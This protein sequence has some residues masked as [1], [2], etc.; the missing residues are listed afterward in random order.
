[1]KLAAGILF[2]TNAAA[3]VKPLFSQ[4]GVKWVVVPKTFRRLLAE[5]WSDYL[6]SE[7][8]HD[9][10]FGRVNRVNKKAIAKRFLTGGVHNYM[11]SRLC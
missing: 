6:L 4:R 9:A 7:L 11:I 10:N 1:M 2:L 8:F 5:A 3:A